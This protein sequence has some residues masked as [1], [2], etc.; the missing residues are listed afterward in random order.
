MMKETYAFAEYTSDIDAKKCVIEL[1]G[2]FVNGHRIMAE[3]AKPKTLT[4][5][6]DSSGHPRIYVGRLAKTVTREDL[7]A[8]FGKFGEITDIMR[9][10]DYAFIEFAE[11]AFAS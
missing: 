4:D 2:R 11:S 8:L 10:E 7:L 5:A 3:P 1:D 6:V 9:K